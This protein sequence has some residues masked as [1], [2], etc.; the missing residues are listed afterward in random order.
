MW[1]TSFCVG[2]TVVFGLWHAR[3]PNYPYR[4]G[5]SAFE[6]AIYNGL[7]KLGW[8]AAM[9]WVTLAC[10]KVNPGCLVDR[11]LSWGFFQPLAKLSYV[12]YLI[13]LE[14]IYIYTNSRTY[15]MVVSYWTVVTRTDIRK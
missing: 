8:A 13:H 12:G 7:S 9:A 11:L 5:Y 3:S 10:A 6:A 15:P 14:L 2:W 4:P 1:L